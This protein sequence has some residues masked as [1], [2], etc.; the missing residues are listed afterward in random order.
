MRR[1]SQVLIAG[2][3]V[4]LAA[5]LLMSAANPRAR[6]EH[7]HGLRLPPSAREIQNRGEFL[8]F[9]D[10]GLASVFEMH[11]NEMPVLLAQLAVRAR[12]APVRASGDPTANGYNVW[13]EDAPT[14]VPGNDQYSGFQRTWKRE[15]TPL[16]MLSCASTTGD[17][18]H[19]EFWSL[20]PDRVLVKLYTDWN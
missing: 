10:H 5:Y 9:L 19:V 3:L 1:V 18:L 4:L 8:A 14:F 6:A 11:T 17:W 7:G 2:V 15:A 12:T 13:P 16:E 20:E